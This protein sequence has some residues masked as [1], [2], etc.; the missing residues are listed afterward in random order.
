[1]V[2]IG[3]MFG[4]FVKDIVDWLY[5]LFRAGESESDSNTCRLDKRDEVT[6]QTEF[7]RYFRG[8]C[9]ELGKCKSV[10]FNNDVC[11]TSTQLIKL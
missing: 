6:V 11:V 5:V 2:K 1:M 3:F 8:H 9:Y 4:S 10:M 7:S